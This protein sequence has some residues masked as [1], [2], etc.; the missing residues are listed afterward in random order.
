MEEFQEL[1]ELINEHFG[2]SGRKRKSNFVED[3]SFDDD[4]EVDEPLSIK[5][6]AEHFFN[7]DENDERLSDT[8]E[9]VIFDVIQR[10]CK[11]V[12]M[13]LNNFSTQ[14]IVD[15]IYSIRELENLKKKS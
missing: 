4:S 6:R 15:H 2:V 7:S 11:C 12:K 8:E 3:T 13:C 5:N 1:D 9:D 14:E 10:G